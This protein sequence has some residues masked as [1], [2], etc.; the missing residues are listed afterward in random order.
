M[1]LSFLYHRVGT[2][3]NANSFSVLEDHFGYIANHFTTVLPGDSL[4]GGLKI[5]LTFDDATVDFYHLVYPL[6][7]K[8]QLSAVLS[9]PIQYIED[10]NPL[11]CSWGQ[12]EEMAQNPRLH[13]A[14]HSIHHQNLLLPGINLEEEIVGSKKILETNL[15]V[16]IRTFVYPLG[17]FNTEIHRQVKSHYEFAM[18]IGSAWNSSWHNWSG[19]TYRIICDHLASPDAPFQFHRKLSYSWFYFL[20]TVR[21]R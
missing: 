4:Q 11:Y 15:H 8:L 20:N 19:M 7:Q 14:S 9:V 3:K 12:L 13:I 2:G 5:C 16:P 6:L 10:Q 21:G 1:I 17:K 18:R